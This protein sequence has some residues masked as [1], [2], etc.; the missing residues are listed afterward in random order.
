VTG[1]MKTTGYAPDLAD[2]SA[3]LDRRNF[4]MQA[5]LKSVEALHNEL[6]LGS[7]CRLLLAMARERL[8]V[9]QAAIL[10]H[11]EP[12]GVVQVYAQHGLDDGVE[13]ISFPATDGI[14]WRLL[15]AGEPFSVIDLR[16]RPR[17]QD[18]FEQHELAELNGQTW[19]PLA[20]PN[21]VVGVLS[22][23]PSRRQATAQDLNFL[24]HLASQA[25][26]AINTA[27]LYESIQIA[28]KDLDRS[29]HKLS[30]LF[31]VTR[32]L[33]AVQDL[34]RLLKMILERAI[35]S[36][37]AEKGS[38]ML[39]DEATDELVIR[40]VYGLPD[41]EVERKINDG[42]I[43]CS[44]FGCGEGIA[45]QVLESGETVRVN[46]VEDEKGFVKREG[47]QQ[48][49]SILCVPLVVEQEV[50][51][52]INITNRKG[53]GTFGPEDE[54]IL[55]SLGNQAA[56]AIARTRLYEAAITDGLTGLFV[57]R[58]AMHRLGEEVKRARRYG[59]Q[60][61]L[62]MCDIDHFKRVNDTWGHQ[63]GDEV[64]IAVSAALK[65]EMREDIDVAGRYGG[66]EFVLILPA[67]SGRDAAVAAERLRASIEA[68]VV[69]IGGDKTL[70][71]TMSFGVAELDSDGTAETLVG[72]ADAALYASKETG[73]NRV[74][75]SLPGDG[76]HEDIGADT[77]QIAAM[78]ESTL[79]G[80]EIAAP[81]PPS[82]DEE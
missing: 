50:L 4:D 37:D 51:G 62:I 48:V 67:T 22:L 69:D 26:V 42:E 70:S 13:G 61:S 59:S 12:D 6:Q 40:V 3:E 8:L 31:D 68:T 30:M 11:S 1:L 39:L 33:G 36:V 75:L 72:R 38:L 60:L 21:K 76:G 23:G 57:R 19:V 20:M 45:G 71:K 78:V 82:D 52:V 55:G 32:A 56:V 49:R 10:L 58:F 27:Q 44:R 53:G 65:R 9:S 54:E 29:L 24:G 35:D 41:K 79:G 74:T 73:R 64:I 77:A 16:G 46:N 18:T 2:Q 43:Q 25:A 81:S 34:T 66:E 80:G 47:S 14:L 17:F 28:R 15:M 5:L 7:L 63:A